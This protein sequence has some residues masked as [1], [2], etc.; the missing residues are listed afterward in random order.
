MNAPDV[1]E[2]KFFELF[3]RL[4]LSEAEQQAAQGYISGKA[5][6]NVLDSF[7]FE[8]LSVIPADPAIRLFRELV[9]TNQR[10]IAGRLFS[11]LLA[12]GESTCFRMIPMEVIDPQKLTQRKRRRCMRRFL[13]RICIRSA[14]TPEI[15][16]LILHAGKQKY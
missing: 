14:R 11:V 13:G 4:R 7:I 8:D 12:K 1:L 3:N 16:C 9:K 6:H 10:D 2:E 5:E 15:V